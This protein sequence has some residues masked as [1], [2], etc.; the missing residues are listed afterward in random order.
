MHLIHDRIVLSIT[1]Y[2]YQFF[3]LGYEK[4]HFLTGS[5]SCIRFV[6][7]QNDYVTLKSQFRLSNEKK[8]AENKL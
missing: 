2:F 4:S 3:S 8:H 6:Q 1:F 5:D 7:T